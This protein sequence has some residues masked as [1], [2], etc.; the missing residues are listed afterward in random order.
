MVCRV[1]GLLVVVY[2]GFSHQ[3]VVLC[4]VRVI[5][6]CV[7]VN[8]Q[9]CFVVEVVACVRRVVDGLLVVVYSGFSHQGVSLDDS[10]SSVVV[11]RIPGI[12]G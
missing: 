12:M 10:G 6:C 9:G 1:A 3:G 7:D 4:V 11:I 8:H 5:L 2:S